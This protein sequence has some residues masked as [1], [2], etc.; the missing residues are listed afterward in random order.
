MI[1]E[2]LKLEEVVHRLSRM[3]VDFYAG[4]K[5]ML[6]LLTESGVDRCPAAVSVAYLSPY[7]ADHPEVIEGWLH[8]SQKP[9]TNTWHFE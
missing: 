4:S 1:R 3:S 6:Q 5:S 9:Y 2:K 7:I 8:W